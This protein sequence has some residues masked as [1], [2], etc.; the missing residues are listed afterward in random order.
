MRIGTQMRSLF[1]GR[2]REPITSRC[3]VREDVFEFENDA[4]EGRKERRIANEVRPT[5]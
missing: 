2:H 4:R 1:F 3:D 5:L